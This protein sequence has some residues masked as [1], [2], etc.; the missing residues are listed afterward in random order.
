[1][2]TSIEK[3]PQPPKPPD[4]SMEIDTKHTT[5]NPPTTIS[6][7]E[8]LSTHNKQL[9]K[10]NPITFPETQSRTNK[11]GE[12]EYPQYVI[13]KLLGKRVT[14]QYLRNRLI[15]T[16]KTTEEIVPIDLGY[17]YY[18]VKFLK[19]E[20][21][22]KALQCGPWFINGYYLS[23]KRWQPNF[24]ASEAMEICTSIWLRLP[25]KPTEY[26]DH[27]ILAKIGNRLGKLVNT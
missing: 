14:H 1:M 6:F 3:L 4:E 5:D 2:S 24:V 11:I 26:Y 20:N 16:W 23:V 7:K 9:G 27:K 8:A 12:T 10:I 25:G 15:A 21:M 18:T 19:E 22:N 17:D 13:I